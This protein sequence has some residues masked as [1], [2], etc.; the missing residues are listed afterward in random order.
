MALA[1]TTIHIIENSRIPISIV[2]GEDSLIDELVTITLEI[3]D[4]VEV[5]N[6]AVQI[7]LAIFNSI[8]VS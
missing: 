8:M 2:G 6:T 5:A 1:S 4:K 3:L 7:T